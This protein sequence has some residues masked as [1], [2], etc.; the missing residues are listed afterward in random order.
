MGLGRTDAAGIGLSQTVLPLITLIRF[1]SQIPSFQRPPITLQ[2]QI[3][4]HVA[5]FL[6][7]LR[8]HKRIVLQ[9]VQS[10]PP[11]HSNGRPSD[12]PR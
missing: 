7:P 12:Q 6:S 11:L 8:P 5:Q 10:L 3:A 1:P 4:L 2:W 9:A